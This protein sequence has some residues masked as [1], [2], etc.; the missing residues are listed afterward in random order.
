MEREQINHL[1]S[2]VSETV[3]IPVLFPIKAERHL[4]HQFRKKERSNKAQKERM[5]KKNQQKPTT[6]ASNH[7]ANKNQKPKESRSNL[8]NP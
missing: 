4:A 6:T 2:C 5:K 1:P 7:Q 8:P 3:A